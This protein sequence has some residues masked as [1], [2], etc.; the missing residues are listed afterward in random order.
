MGDL[1]GG[2]DTALTIRNIIFQ[3]MCLQNWG[4]FYPQTKYSHFLILRSETIKWCKFSSPFF[5]S[6]NLSNS[7]FGN[8]SASLFI[9][10]IINVCLTIFP[11]SSEGELWSFCQR[12]ISD[13]SSPLK[14]SL[15]LNSFKSDS[16]QILSDIKDTTQGSKATKFPLSKQLWVKSMKIQTENFNL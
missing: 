14:P 10:Q 3:V 13:G 5:S 16:M 8:G 4:C 15:E 11:S 2:I 6:P 7:V 1:L 12:F 9:L